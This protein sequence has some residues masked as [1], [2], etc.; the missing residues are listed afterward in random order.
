M[1]EVKQMCPLLAP[2]LSRSA[3]P[4][5]RQLQGSR[6]V[7]LTE[8]HIGHKSA[9]ETHVTFLVH[10]FVHSN[11]VCSEKRMGQARADC[12]CSIVPRKKQKQ[13]KTYQ[14]ANFIWSLHIQ[15]TCPKFVFLVRRTGPTERSTTCTPPF[16]QSTSWP[17]LPE[18]RLAVQD[19]RRQ[20][21][22]GHVGGTSRGVTPPE[23]L[24]HPR[25]AVQACAPRHPDVGQGPPKRTLV[26][27][28]EVRGRQP[29]WREG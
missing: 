16:N 5:R 8:N 6:A 11:N 22:S 9:S 2:T 23:G 15:T 7:E 18:L 20:L 3:P 4:L 21:D 26:E 17:H 27:L 25:R 29:S 12:R 14:I 10:S 28:R 24:G 13:N 19:L 1:S